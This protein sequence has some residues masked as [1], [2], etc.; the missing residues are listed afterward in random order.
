MR[1]TG[2][3]RLAVVMQLREFRVVVG[4][5]AAAAACCNSTM[6]TEKFGITAPPQTFTKTP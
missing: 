6:P 3:I 1:N 4:Q 2:G 5:A